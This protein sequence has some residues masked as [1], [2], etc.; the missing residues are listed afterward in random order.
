MRYVK[1]VSLGGIAVGAA[2][3]VALGA[4]PVA[5]AGPDTTGTSPIDTWLYGV[6]GDGVNTLPGF[7]PY[8][9]EGTI[10]HGDTPWFTVDFT[11]SG[12]SYHEV[13]TKVLDPSFGYPSVGTV[14]DQYSINTLNYSTEYPS[15]YTLYS[16]NSIS[17]PSLGTGDYSTW[18]GHSFTNFYVS[19]KAGIEDQMTFGGGP[20][21]TLFDFPASGTGSSDADAGMDQL[22]AD[23]LG[24]VA[25][26]AAVPDLF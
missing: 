23:L 18:F 10:Y 1:L 13:V 15:E 16:N 6:G 3:G 5:A 4:S 25:G 21:I 8:D 24:G 7:A 20:P 19:D 12:S 22:M 9:P 2:F 17:D 14:A 26:S 11:G